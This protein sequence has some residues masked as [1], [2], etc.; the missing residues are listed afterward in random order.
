MSGLL[1][2]AAA[3][4]TAPVPPPIAQ[5][6]ADCERPSYAVDQLICSDPELTALDRQLGSLLRRVAADRLRAPLIEDHDA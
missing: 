4:M 1:L 3:A 5:W 6:S 2:L